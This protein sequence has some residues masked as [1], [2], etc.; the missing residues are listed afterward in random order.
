MIEIEGDL[1]NGE[2]STSKAIIKKKNKLNW[3]YFYLI[4]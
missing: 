2:L 3:D 1:F 4:Y